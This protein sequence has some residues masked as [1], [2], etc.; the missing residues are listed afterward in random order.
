MLIG[1]FPFFLFAQEGVVKGRLV[2]STGQ[3]LINATVSVLQKKDSS[4]VSYAM[5]DSKGSFEIKH[6]A[7]GEYLI[8]ISFTGYQEYK[9]SFSISDDKRVS[10]IGLIMMWPEF[11][12]LTGVVVTESPIRIN[13]DTISFKARAFNSNPNATV[14]EV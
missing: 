1:L 9:T 7:L 2:D 6:L 12:T 14:E 13:G 5:S 3:I 10:E 11:K 4:L 8:Y